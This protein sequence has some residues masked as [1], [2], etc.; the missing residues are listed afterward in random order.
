MTSISRRLHSA[1]GPGAPGR[2]FE[3]LRGAFN[4]RLARD[5]DNL[6][7]LEAA[8][9]RADGGAAL[10]FEKLQFSA[11]RLHGAAAVFETFEV[12]Q[13]ASAL[14]TAATSAL[15]ANADKS[16]VAVST[17]LQNLLEVLARIISE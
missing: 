2:E 9:A 16:D 12:A 10:A 6:Q 14:E 8:L 17:A 1:P 13:A 3:K 7:S 11:H 15:S 5:R 4:V